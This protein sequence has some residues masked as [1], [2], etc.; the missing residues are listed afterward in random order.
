ML[1]QAIIDAQQLKEA[2]Q[3]NAE[4][5]LIEKYQDEIREA[6]ETILEQDE[7][8]PE[9]EETAEMGVNDQ[10]DL[11]FVEDL[12]P[13]QKSDSAEIV[14]IDLDKLEEMMAEE[15]E[16]DGLDASEMGDR[17]EIAEDIESLLGEEE[18]ELDESI[19]SS[20]VEELLSETDAY[21]D[22]D[23]SA[24]EAAE[25]EEES[26][27]GG[28]EE[29]EQKTKFTGEKD[30][31]VSEENKKPDFPDIDNDGDTS[32]P[33]SKAA[34]EKAG[35]RDTR[36]D[37]GGGHGDYKIAKE[38]SNYPYNENRQLQKNKSLLKE[39]KQLT[40]KVQLL[41]EKLNKYGTFITKLKNKLN[42]SNLTN[43]RLLYQ[44]RILNS[45]SL[46]ERQKDRVVEAISNAKSVEEAK[47]IFETLQ[48][49]VGSISKRT[50]PESLNEVVTRSSSAFMPRREAKQKD[51]PFAERMKVLA[52]LKNNK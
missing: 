13:A 11:V 3:K 50:M 41:E 26:A 27:E 35:K 21:L 9:I 36:D 22:P 42:E 28:T 1:E 46:N 7:V 12:P 15:L 33:I 52:G 2:A 45:T 30:D 40:N 38:K 49:A 18:I 43:A 4:E 17:E 48:S 24:E 20:I 39:Q 29:S 16:E 5:T 37:M 10:G 31:L 51:D 25:A 8:L 47:I 19:L 6:V 44:N 32:E 34:K 23:T 14:T